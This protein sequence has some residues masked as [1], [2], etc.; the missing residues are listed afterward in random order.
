[1]ARQNADDEGSDTEDDDDDDTNDDSNDDD[2]DGVGGPDADAPNVYQAKS[3]GLRKKFLSEFSDDEVAEMWQVHNFM[4]FVSLCTRNAMRDPPT[5]DC[6]S[7][8]ISLMRT[9]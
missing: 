9:Y 1:M 3:Q 7:L 5:H 8:F 4:T 6:V 2:N